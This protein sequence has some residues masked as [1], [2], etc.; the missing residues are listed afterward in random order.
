MTIVLKRFKLNRGEGGCVA[1]HGRGEGLELGISI[2][3]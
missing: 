2:V 1:Y 3:E